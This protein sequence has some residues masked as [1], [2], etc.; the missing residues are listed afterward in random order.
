[1]LAVV[2]LF[3]ATPAPAGDFP[4]LTGL[5]NNDAVYKQHQADVA[6]YYRR[7]RRAQDLPELSIYR[8]EVSDDESL[9][10]LASRL[11]LPYSSLASLNRISGPAIPPGRDYILVPNMPGMFVPLEPETS[12]ENL[13]HDSREDEIAEAR[14][15]TIREDRRVERFRFFPGSDFDRVERLAFLRRLFTRPVQN[16]RVSSHFGF[17]KGPFDGRPQFHGGVD[18]AAPAGT[19][20]VAA[21]EGRVADVGYDPQ[22][23]RYVLLQHEE[24]YES[25][26]GHLGEVPVRLN[27]RLSSGTIVGYVGNSGRSTGPHLHFEIR[28]YGKHR[29]PLHHLPELT[30]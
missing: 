29:D 26:Y 14:T 1:M 21:R 8:Y 16:G 13:L 25:F 22:Y 19:E 3:G 20:V 2:A 10:T 27:D 11:M 9:I 6:E 17:R 24:G 4:R 28:Q 12:L 18:F 15:V 7:S 5:G 30:R 23:G